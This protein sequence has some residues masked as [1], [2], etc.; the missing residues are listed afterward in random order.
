MWPLTQRPTMFSAQAG[1][2]IA[3]PD[4]FVASQ[5]QYSML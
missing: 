2:D 3:G 4:L 1:I 5:P